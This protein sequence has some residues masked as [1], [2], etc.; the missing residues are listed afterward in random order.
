MSLNGSIAHKAPQ[1]LRKFNA[2]WV[3]ELRRQALDADPQ[4]ASGI[5]YTGVEVLVTIEHG[6]ERWVVGPAHIVP[7]IVTHTWLSGSFR[8]AYGRRLRFLAR[9]GDYAHLTP[10]HG[11]PL[12]R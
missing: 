2:A 3:L 6:H 9:V 11:Y 5:A 4:A 8:A 1:L 7:L 10:Q 12:P